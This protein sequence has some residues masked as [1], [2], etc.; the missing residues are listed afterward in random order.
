MRIMNPT[1]E[2]YRY[3]ASISR[4]LLVGLVP[5]IHRSV[6][7]MGRVYA[8]L[9]LAII[10]FCLVATPVTATVGSVPGTELMFTSTS[11]TNSAI[12]DSSSPVAQAPPPEN[13]SDGRANES[14]ESAPGA[15]TSNVT[16]E[17]P[18]RFIAANDP[19]PE[20]NRSEVEVL[21]VSAPSLSFRRNLTTYNTS[22]GLRPYELDRHDMTLAEAENR[23][24]S[25]DGYRT[26]LTR[27]VLVPTEERWVSLLD[28]RVAETQIRRDYTQ[29]TSGSN[30]ILGKPNWKVDAY[31]TTIKG[32]VPVRNAVVV[33]ETLRFGDVVIPIRIVV[34]GT[35]EAN[36]GTY[37]SY[38]DR[39][40]SGTAALTTTSGESSTVDL[41]QSTFPTNQTVDWFVKGATENEVDGVGEIAVERE[42]TV[43]TAPE[44]TSE[45][46]EA[47]S[48]EDRSDR[49]GTAAR[50]ESPSSG[51]RSESDAASE[52]NTETETTMVSRESDNT[53][54][55]SSSN[56]LTVTDYW[57]TVDNDTDNN[58]HTVLA[59][60]WGG[61]A[62]I[63]PGAYLNGSFIVRDGPTRVYAPSDYRVGVPP[64]LSETYEYDG[65]DNDTDE[66][67][68]ATVYE[69]WELANLTV[70][71]S[72]RIGSTEGK[73]GESRG[74]FQFDS[75]S[76]NSVEMESTVSLTLTHTYGI[77]ITCTT[78]PSPENETT[79]SET[80]EGNETVER[81]E[82]DTDA[83]GCEKAPP[84]EV[85]VPEDKGNSSWEGVETI[86]IVHT[87]RQSH[88][89]L[90]H[91]PENL[92]VEVYVL[93][94]SI[95]EMYIVLEGEQSFSTE[96]IG[97]ITVTNGDRSFELQ[98]PWR[99]YP[100]ALHQN[101]TTTNGEDSIQYPTTFAANA[102][103]GLSEG[104]IEEPNATT[105]AAAIINNGS[106]TTEVRRI[107]RE[108][109][110]T[111]VPNLYRDYAEPEAW[112]VQ[113]RSL[114]I[115]AVRKNV[116]QNV[117]NEAL[118]K[119]VVRDDEPVPL[120]DLWGGFTANVT[121][122]NLSRTNA[123]AVD[124]FGT[125]IDTSVT[126]IQYEQTELQFDVN[127]D[128]VQIRLLSEGEPLANKELRVYGAEETTVTTDGDGY[129][130][131]TA[132]TY[133]VRATFNGT[134]FQ[135]EADTYYERSSGG[136]VVPFYFVQP[137]L[138]VTGY[139]DLMI[140]NVTLVLEWILLGVVF[141]FGYRYGWGGKPDRE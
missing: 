91:D 11:T 22:L 14:N 62:R 136:I 94:K 125:P 18:F 53:S 137:V 46:E 100:I 1:H 106:T 104:P 36:I 6:S 121:D 59:D 4:P 63:T 129:A 44:G 74:V 119:S 81:N 118:P 127:N 80:T 113:N 83:S 3:A 2:C 35:G 30:T 77:N 49:L 102:S 15:V 32:Y 76:G 82:T 105:E 5:I 85:D 40:D 103:E 39:V 10:V 110:V 116:T 89:L 43:E 65:P 67:L 60:H 90:I 141:Y 120:Y 123:S 108:G 78:E 130:T 86:S 47:S 99:F 51:E 19:D 133:V 7:A 84:D 107:E 33:I 115:L 139:I 98:S 9:P 96:A 16:G 52:P 17:G 42:E 20:R 135:E 37:E 64:G 131:V 112:T 95:N 21:D 24:V 140:S 41:T 109:K 28:G 71:K 55:D 117:S 13:G 75:V 126:Q 97:E 114:D 72:V 101:V 61:I 45:P 23:S 26:V 73:P 31:A 66:E 8:G 111:G 138:S 68:E 57:I 34:P 132:D 88:S 27:G 38:Q 58:T 92:S 29:N 69:T 56:P 12:A 79:D 25:T 134:S 48:T 70:D 124:I 50:P 93:N 122:E 87:V 128:T 54:T